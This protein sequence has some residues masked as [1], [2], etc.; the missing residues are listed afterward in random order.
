MAL[1]A[2]QNQNPSPGSLW[3]DAMDHGCN[4][5]GRVIR[6]HTCRYA[7]GCA[8]WLCSILGTAA[9]VTGPLGREVLDQ[10]MWSRRAPSGVLKGG[11]RN[12][13][14]QQLWVPRGPGADDMLQP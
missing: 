14:R 5:A 7:N 10:C 6:R 1:E 3:D 8:E 4:P 13:P 9:M 11:P 2:E 12:G